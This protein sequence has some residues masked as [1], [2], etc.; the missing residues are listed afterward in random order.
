MSARGE[1]NGCFRNLWQPTQRTMRGTSHDL[2]SSAVGSAANI[3]A[4]ALPGTATSG[5]QPDS[6]TT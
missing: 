5:S 6:F 3:V 1:F 2:V 4:P